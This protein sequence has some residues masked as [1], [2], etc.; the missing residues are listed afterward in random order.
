MGNY[1]KISG[2]PFFKNET[3]MNMVHLLRKKLTLQKI[4]MAF[5]L[6]MEDCYPKEDLT[7]E[8]Y[9]DVF[10]QLLNDTEPLY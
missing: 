2:Q 7:Y 3:Q 6:Y 5:N 8:E 4:C 10:S 9:D 1:L